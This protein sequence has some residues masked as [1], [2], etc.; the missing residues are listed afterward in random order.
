MKQLTSAVI[1]A[2]L[3]MAFAHAC[4]ATAFP[5]VYG[6]WLQQIDNGRYEFINGAG[7]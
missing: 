4:V 5:H 1:L 6:V 7:E 3:V 2:L